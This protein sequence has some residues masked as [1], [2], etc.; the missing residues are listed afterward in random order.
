MQQPVAQIPW[1]HNTVLLDKL[2]SSEERLWYAEK[3]IENGWSR[4]VLI[5]Q[6]EGGLYQRQAIASKSQILKLVC[7]PRKV[8][9]PCKR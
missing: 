1:G 8:S 6:I 5:H 7:P 4:N 3:V 2:S 9:L